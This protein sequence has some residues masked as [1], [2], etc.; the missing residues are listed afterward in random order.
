MV[1]SDDE[2]DSNK[3]KKDVVNGNKDDK[4]NDCDAKKDKDNSSGEQDTGNTQV[5]DDSECKEV[6]DGSGGDSNN[7]SVVVAQRNNVKQQQLS[8]DC[9]VIEKLDGGEMISNGVYGSTP[10]SP[11]TQKLKSEAL[12]NV[13]GAKVSTQCKGLLARFIKTA[14]FLCSIVCM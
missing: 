8:I 7:K 6:K 2:D 10:D 11:N 5:K 3:K 12:A 13:R 9:N 14:R 1:I 4:E